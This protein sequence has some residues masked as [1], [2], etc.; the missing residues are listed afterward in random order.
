MDQSGRNVKILLV[1][2]AV[3]VVCAL[4][5]AQVATSGLG[6][7][8][9]TNQQ[10]S[11]ELTEATENPVIERVIDGDT[12]ALA[13]GRRVR[14]L[15]LNAP[16]KSQCFAREATAENERLLKDKR[17]R[18]EKDV[19]NRDKSGRLLRY[20]F[21]A[22][23]SG[24]EVFVNDYLLRHGF[25]RVLNIPPDLSYEGQFNGASGDAK[26]QERGLWGMCN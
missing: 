24:R 15:G 10:Q 23:E 8:I 12:I 2:G 21:A 18:L 5:L 1:C 22:D 17:V 19:T 16:E 4:I 3:L 11:K 13:D 25:A 7:R 9:L 14:Y 6:A 20:V 26:F